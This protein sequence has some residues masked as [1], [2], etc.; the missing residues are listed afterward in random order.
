[1]KVVLFCGGL[2]TR[3]RE[4]SETIPKPLAPV[5]DRPIVVH[6]MQYYAHFGHTQF[7]LCLGY[8]GDMIREYFAQPG[9][10]DPSWTI[11]FVDTGH[12]ATTGER[13]LSVR[14]LVD[15]DP[16]FLA[17]YSDGLSDLPLPSYLQR[18]GERDAIAG[19][20]SVRSPQ[21]FHVVRMNDDGE[22]ISLVRAED[23]DVWIN[24]GFFVLRPSVFD[25][26]EPGDEL[27]E[28]PFRRLVHAHRLYS[29]RHAGFWAPL[30]TYKDKVNFDR[31][32]ASGDCPWQV[33]RD[34]STIA[35]STMLGGGAWAG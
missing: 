9:V 3:L 28:A 23:A 35:S 6:L 30:D 12:D 16:M 29:Y 20:V 19:F 34:R 18:F 22:V 4:F 21:S 13:L 26:I 32:V 11:E 27:V 17:N 5:G 15:R 14:H 2:G 7:V 24:G 10:S 25:V 33:W 31:R 1:M 8:R